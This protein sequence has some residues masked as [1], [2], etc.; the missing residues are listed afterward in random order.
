MNQ[1]GNNFDIT[2]KENTDINSRLFIENYETN[3]FNFLIDFQNNNNNHIA[4]KKVFLNSNFG[5]V[6]NYPF[7]IS[8]F[9]QNFKIYITSTI[10]IND[11][12]NSPSFPQFYVAILFRTKQY[13]IEFINLS[14]KQISNESSMTKHQNNSLELDAEQFLYLRN[15]ENKIDM[16]IIVSKTFY[17]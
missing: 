2:K 16:K 3:F 1:F 11:P 4:N 10:D 13:G 8:I 15:D 5:I 9:F 14:N 12:I 17:Y 7:Q 6:P